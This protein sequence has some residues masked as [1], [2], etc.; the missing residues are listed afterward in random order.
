M[1]V[2]VY[3][4]KTIENAIS[5]NRDFNNYPII[6]ISCVGEKVKEMEKY[7]SLQLEFGDD[8]STFNN[9]H[10]RQIIDFVEKNK[11]HPVFYVHC[12]AGI[13]R[14]GA[15]GLWI[16]RYLGLDETEFYERNTRIHPNLYVLDVLNGVARTNFKP[17]K[18]DYDFIW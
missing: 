10:A 9:E 15:V 16:T 7:N 2:F 12:D 18:S 14:S 13:S 8:S 3:P 1:M 6:S 4:R 5:T 17:R 11:N